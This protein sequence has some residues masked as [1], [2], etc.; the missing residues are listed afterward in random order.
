MR[1]SATLIIASSTSE[2]RTSLR[3][4]LIL[5][6]MELIS[7][8]S[9][10]GGGA[11]AAPSSPLAGTAGGFERADGGTLL[12]DELGELPPAAQVRLLRILQDG[13]LERV[14]GTRARARGR[15]APVEAGGGRP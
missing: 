4:G 6:A 3:A 5:T 11:S 10:A 15:R 9:G 7:I 13:W 14:G 8:A 2:R 1:R 12:L